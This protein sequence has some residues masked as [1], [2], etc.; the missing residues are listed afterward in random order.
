MD[1][2][3]RYAVLPYVRRV[4]SVTS[5]IN[6][7]LNRVQYKVQ[8]GKKKYVIPIFGWPITATIT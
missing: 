4:G 8:N 1:S 6:E 3:M 5:A 2:E 7:M